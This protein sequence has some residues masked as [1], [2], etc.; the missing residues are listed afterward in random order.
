[1]TSVNCNVKPRA[2]RLS[3]MPRATKVRTATS[4]LT[5]LDERI[6]SG[7]GPLLYTRTGWRNCSWAIRGNIWN[8]P[9]VDANLRFIA[10]LL[11][12]HFLLIQIRLLFLLFIFDISE[13][14]SIHLEMTFGNPTVDNYTF[15]IMGA[16]HLPHINVVFC[17]L[18]NSA[19]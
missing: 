12:L 18:V 19:F 2:A 6:T 9:R 14:I 3:N 15:D 10:P 13:T 1:M 16:L 11:T 7:L 5:R 17:I 8:C 4:W